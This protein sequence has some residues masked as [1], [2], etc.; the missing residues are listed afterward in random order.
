MLV[1]LR[2]SL[3]KP[4]KIIIGDSHAIFTFG[5]TIKSKRFSVTSGN[6]LIVWM[7]P[8]LMYTVAQNGFR[9]DNQV[10]NI[11]KKVGNKTPV[12]FIFGEIDCRVHFVQ[13]N[14]NLGNDSFD[15]I[16]MDYKKS[17]NTI[18]NKF[19]FSRAII[20]SPIP[21]SDLGTNDLEFPRNGSL[22]ERAQVTKMIT[23]SLLRLSS[24]EFVVFNV[25][26]VLSISN[27]SI[28]PKYS[29]DG[30]HLNCLGRVQ[31][32]SKFCLEDIK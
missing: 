6:I 32:N 10:K 22:F 13:R 30:I 1:Y 12:V 27:G 5:E 23:E 21:P 29:D 19:G 17:I 3:C 2:V 15:K 14:L 20:F 26:S 16:A 7:G 24:P 8:L 31:L 11:L 28:N 4:N 18:V 25:S 9:F